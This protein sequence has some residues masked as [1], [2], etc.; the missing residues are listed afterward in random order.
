MK[1]YLWWEHLDDCHLLKG[2]FNRGNSIIGELR[3]DEG[4]FATKWADY[5]NGSLQVRNRR[6]SKAT[7]GEAMMKL[8]EIVHN[9]YKDS[10]AN[11]SECSDDCGDCGCDSATTVEIEIT[12]GE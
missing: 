3:P 7:V 5:S 9:L 6:F 10:F 11:S 8:E 1:M 4:G 2:D 12:G